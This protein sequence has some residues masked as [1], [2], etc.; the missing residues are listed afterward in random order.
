MPAHLSGENLHCYL[1]LGILA[2]DFVDRPVP[3]TP[4]DRSVV[5]WLDLEATGLLGG[6]LLVLAALLSAFS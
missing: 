3:A 2:A 4:V 6:A 5:F 1:C